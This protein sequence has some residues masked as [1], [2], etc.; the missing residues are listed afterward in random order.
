[1]LSARRLEAV[2]TR[3]DMAIG[4]EIDRRGRAIG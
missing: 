3:D 2:W 1:M 4:G